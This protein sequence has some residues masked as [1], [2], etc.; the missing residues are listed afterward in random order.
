MAL[1][2]STEMMIGEKAPSFSLLGTD[3]KTHSFAGLLN[4]KKAAVIMFI[5]NHC[6]YVK[7][8]FRRIA[9]LAE[10]YLHKEVAVIGI[11]PN[12]E[13]VYSEDSFEN[14]KK[15]VVKHHFVFHYLRDDQQTVAKAYN[16]VCTPE[17][18]VTDANGII[19]FHGAFDDNW[20][21]EA[22]VTTRY[23]ENAIEDILA[24]REVKEVTPHSMGC[25]IKWKS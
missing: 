17:F 18:F 12:D 8:H 22:E 21:D 4:G 19:R 1:M 15:I 20:K 5:C 23:L 10:K 2:H 25:S 14:M 6:P 16:A 13:N 24:G 11:N 7:A 3:D 9:Q